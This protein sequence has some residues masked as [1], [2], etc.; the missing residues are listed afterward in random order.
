MTITTPYEATPERVREP[1]AAAHARQTRRGRITLV[2]LALACVVPVAASYLAYYVWPP[3]GRVNYGELL[4]PAPL[5]ELELAG[6]A[7]QPALMRADLAGRWTLLYAGPGACE[8]PCEAALYA[9]RQSRLAQA[10]EMERVARVWLITD[11]AAPRGALLA[12]HDGL[13]VARA[14]AAWLA[15]LP[16]AGSG[17]HIYLVDPL[18]NVMMRFPEQADAKGVI[19]DLQRLLKYSGLGRG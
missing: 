12:A 1:E 18:G 15:Q 8:A 19:K 5:A 17:R 4:P 7:D 10:N 11:G 9:M 16:G 14:E 6:V 2:L 13:R 3:Q